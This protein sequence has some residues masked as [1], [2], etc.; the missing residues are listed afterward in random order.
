MTFNP[1]H[2]FM[3]L[4]LEL[5]EEGE[6]HANLRDDEGRSY[7]LPRELVE[8]IPPKEPTLPKPGEVWYFRNRSAVRVVDA[9]G[10]AR[11]VNG[12]VVLP[13]ENMNRET[14]AEYHKMFNADGSP[15]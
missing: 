8:E 6:T 2:C 5:V 4:E 12:F 10:N 13:R 9:E 1:T 3:E 14:L 11:N 7:T 15:V